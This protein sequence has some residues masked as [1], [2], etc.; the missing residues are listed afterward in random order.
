MHS[1]NETNYGLTNQREF[2][3]MNKTE[4]IA[5]IAVSADLSKKAAGEALD[6]LMEAVGA[7]LEKGESVVLPGFGTFSPRERAARD[8]RNPQTGAAIK[9]AASTSAGFKQGKSLKDRLNK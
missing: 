7:T 2:T 4:L 9:I 6:G 8:G 3:I 5:A 1:N